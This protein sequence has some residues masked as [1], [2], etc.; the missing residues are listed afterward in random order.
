MADPAQGIANLLVDASVGAAG[1]T[2]DWGIFIGKL[3]SSP[4]AAIGI[5]TTGG[6]PPNP[7]YLLD[8]P[9]V[10]VMVRGNPNGYVAGRAKAQAVKDAIL[11]L[12]SQEV[13]GD[14]WVQFNM[15]GD[16]VTVG[17]D[18]NN[19]PLFSVNF[20]LIIEPAESDTSNRIPL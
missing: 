5:V 14:L 9:S 11:G 16:V 7:Q 2:A 20:A 13:N 17:F 19:C 12:P 8:Y 3:P 4:K 15:I 10:Q 18:E 1:G 6:T